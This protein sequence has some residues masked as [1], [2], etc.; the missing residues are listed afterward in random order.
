MRMRALLIVV[1]L[2]G[3]FAKAR[4]ACAHRACGCGGLFASAPD[5][6]DQVLRTREGS[7]AAFVGTVRRVAQDSTH[8]FA[9]FR[10]TRSW[11]GV[12]DT[13]VRIVLGPAPKRTSVTNADG[14]GQVT[15]QWVTTSCHLSVAMGEEWLIFAHRSRTGLLGATQCS[16][17]PRDRAGPVQA[18]LDSL[19]AR[20]GET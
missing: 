2:T 18:A 7:D 20:G 4:E 9:E 17:T 14:S 15:V 1:A 11:K 10:I 13:L 5:F 19:R 3:V 12:S 8:V 16:A 6:A